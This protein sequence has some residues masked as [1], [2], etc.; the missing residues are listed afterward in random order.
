MNDLN[1]LNK[2][3]FRQLE[4]LDSVD[5]QGDQL[6]AELNRSSAVVNVSRTIIKNANLALRASIAKDD[7]LSWESANKLPKMLSYQEDDD[8]E[9][10]SDS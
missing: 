1:D 6:E 4:R 3:L 2:A 10:D 8:D 9:E 5:L 7:K